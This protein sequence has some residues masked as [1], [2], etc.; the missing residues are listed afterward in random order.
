MTELQVMTVRVEA[1]YPHPGADRLELVLFGNNTICSQ[2]GKY[3]IGDIVAHFPPD[4][5]IPPKIADQLGVTDYLKSA[6]YP[7]DTQK[8]KC[9]VGAIRLRGCPSFGFI[10]KVDDPVDVDLSERFHAVKFEPPEPDWFKVGLFAK[11]HPAFHQYTS[12]ENYR[13]SK[14]RGAFEPGQPVRMTEKCHGTNSRMGIIDGQIMVG[15]HR[16]AMQ[17][18]DARSKKSLYWQHFTSEIEALLR[19]LSNDKHNV[20]VFGEIFGSK[21]QKMDYGIFGSGG[22]RVFDI[23]VDGTYLS[24]GQLKELAEQFKIKLVPL[25]Y[26]GP[27]IPELVESLVDGPTILAGELDIRCSFKG[28]EGVVITPLEETFSPILGGRLILKAVSVDYLASRKSD[29]H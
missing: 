20:I 21:V 19:H 24:W 12:I 9:R 8:T 10:F 13:N 17:E 5:L 25:L 15:S 28:R 29:S 3:Q 26:E 1:V 23:S 2:K 6:I 16:K 7:G 4:I 14:F 18:I 11:D 22:Y 27:F